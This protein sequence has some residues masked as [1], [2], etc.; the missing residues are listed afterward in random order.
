LALTPLSKT[1]ATTSTALPDAFLA[2]EVDAMANEDHV[3][4]LWRPDAGVYNRYELKDGGPVPDPALAAALAKTTGPSFTGNT[5]PLSPT[6]MSAYVTALQKDAND[7]GV[8]AVLGPATCATNVA[9]LA[10][11]QWAATAHGLVPLPVGVGLTNSMT[12]AWADPARAAWSDGLSVDEIGFAIEAAQFGSWVDDVKA[13]IK[14][15]LGGGR[16]RCTPI[17]TLLIRFGATSDADI[18]MTVG[19]ERPVLFALAMLRSRKLSGVPGKVK[20]GGGGWVGWGG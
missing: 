16:V 18:S 15:D 13:V 19:M 3:A 1:I 11:Q 2:S 5:P 20:Q 4:L 14:L 7:T 10:A 12:T 9:A 8:G 6:L 17:G